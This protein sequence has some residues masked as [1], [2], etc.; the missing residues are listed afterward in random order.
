[1]ALSDAVRAFA[2][3]AEAPHRPGLR[4]M[5]AAGPKAWTAVPVVEILGNWWGRDVDLSYFEVSG[6]EYDSVYEVGRIE[7]ELGFVAERVGCQ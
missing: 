6:R 3:A 2:L 5:N 1:M 7:Q 4:I